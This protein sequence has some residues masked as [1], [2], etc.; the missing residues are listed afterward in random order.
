[1]EKKNMNVT[2]KLLILLKKINKIHTQLLALP[3]HK[4]D[5]GEYNLLCK[6]FENF[7]ETVISD[8]IDFDK[9]KKIVQEEIENV[10]K[11]KMAGIFDKK[12]DMIISEKM[13]TIDKDIQ[14]KLSE[15]LIDMID[16]EEFLKKFQQYKPDLYEL[17][18]NRPK[19]FRPVH[20]D[21]TK[22]ER[23]I[24]KTTNYK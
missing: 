3:E 4:R 9:I 10:I 20:K 6:E 21:G 11:T 14:D 15:K 12:Y 13:K 8:F 1:M 23:K 7:L 24:K 17:I 16:S 18:K 5:F 22:K 19:E 2:E